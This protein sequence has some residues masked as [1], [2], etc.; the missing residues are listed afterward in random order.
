MIDHAACPLP[1]PMADIVLTTFNAKYAHTAFGLR[2]LMANLGPLRERARIVELDVSQRPIDALERILAENPK[3]VGVGVYI[4]N[5]GPATEL[6]ALIKAV[7]PQTVVVLG[8]PEVSHEADRQA[9]ACL[10][11]HVIQGEA[12]LAFAGLCGEL[13]R[14]RRPA[15]KVMRAELP[16]LGTVALPYDLYDE[17]DIEHRVIYVE[18]SRGCPFG[19]EFC[20]SSLD[21]AVRRFSPDR[22][23]GQMQALLDRGATQFKFVDR[24]FNLNVDVARTI[25]EFFLDRYKSG[26]FL[27]FEVI[28]DHLPDEL[29]EIIRRFPAGAMQFEIGVQTFN[30]EVAR[31]INRR[32]D[33]RK[34]EQNLRFLRDQT[35]VHRHCDLIAGL[36]GED[37][38]SFAGGF[39]RLIALGPQEIQ[40]GMLKRLRGAPIARHSDEWRMVYSP[41]PP[42]EVLQTEAIDFAT[43]QRLR[44]FA[45]YWDMVG[46]S[47]NFVQTLPMLW[48][49][50]SPFWSFMG[51]CDWLFGRLGRAHAVSLPAL[52]ELLLEYLSGVLHRD[53][54][55]VA[56]ALWRDYQRG[57]RRE[58]PVFLRQDLPQEKA[59][60]AARGGLPRRQNRHLG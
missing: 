3:I 29:R 9:I 17:R 49:G 14:G 45:R 18:A 6:V 34:V 24:T 48:Q 40:V 26:M 13:L 25:L 44:R 51:L 37:I 58:M 16:D 28:P 4:W 53:R 47:G 35:A 7:S 22:F 41:N 10:A 12:D 56:E 39:D 32:Q 2:Y 8:G 60:R 42:Y 43:M 30:E 36:P 5:V 59:M 46:N 21:A 57:G 38:G 50:E 31:R 54:R 55:M 27:H 52:G 23:L 19:C 33:M 20:L 1:R 11:D 15:D